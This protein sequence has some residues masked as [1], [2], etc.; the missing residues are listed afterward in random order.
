[1]K[2]RQTTELFRCQMG[3]RQMY[4]TENLPVDG[5]RDAPAFFSRPYVSTELR[6]AIALRLFGCILFPETCSPV[7]MLPSVAKALDAFHQ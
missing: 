7:G 2:R 6:I 5:S 1:M 3:V 4:L